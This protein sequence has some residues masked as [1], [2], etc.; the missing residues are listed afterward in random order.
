MFDQS[1]ES[2]ALDDSR[3]V[4]RQYRVSWVQYVRPLIT[5]G[6]LLAV[7][8]WFGWFAAQLRYAW[9]LY[10]TVGLG[11]VAALVG[12]Y[13]VAFL[14]SIRLFTNDAGVWIAKGVMPWE[15]SVS[16]IHWEE[17]G[18]A[19]VMT[20]FLAWATGAYNVA[21]LHRYT[22]K[23]EIWVARISD[24]HHFAGHVNS[25]INRHHGVPVPRS[26]K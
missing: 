6:I 24:G 14:R 23:P 26:S 11:V 12:V 18:E 9:M 5:C 13:N 15:K 2:N 10:A 22:K 3:V 21:V 16:G 7:L 17:A 1:V 4:G 25:I 8:A 20:G 19:V